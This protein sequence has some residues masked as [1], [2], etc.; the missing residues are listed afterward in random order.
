MGLQCKY[1]LKWTL[2][3]IESNSYVYSSKNK[4]LGFSEVVLGEHDFGKDE[5]CD[6]EGQFC[7]APIIKRKIN[8][9]RDVIV[10]EKFNETGNLENDIALIR[11]QEAVPLHQ[12]NE[13]KSGA[14]PI[15]L[16]WNTN[17]DVET[18]EDQIATTAGWGR[19]VRQAT[20]NSQANL[21]NNNINVNHLQELDLPIANKK[22]KNDPIVT[23]IIR[24][25][26]PDTQICAGGERGKHTKSQI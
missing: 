22:C 14:S 17:L 26:D 13:F 18:Q 10:H 23:K 19:T 16:P 11:I 1:I 15:C 9:N 4:S 24:E 12:E 20:K 2:L 5:D 8:V 21:L 25:F 3:L 7:S 6:F